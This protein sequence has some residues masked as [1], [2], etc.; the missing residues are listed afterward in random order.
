MIS[1]DFLL[2]KRE[3]LQHEQLFI[4]IKDILRQ[5]FQLVVIQVPIRNNQKHNFNLT[6]NYLS[7][8][9]IKPSVEVLFQ[10]RSFVGLQPLL[11]ARSYSIK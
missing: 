4:V 3:Y 5:G 1:G 9:L 10:F 8:C 2:K 7:Q 11:Q 6:L